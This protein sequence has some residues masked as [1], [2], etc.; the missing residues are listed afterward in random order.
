MSHHEIVLTL[1]DP[2]RR[3]SRSL[4]ASTRS[5]GL[6][7]YGKGRRPRQVAVRVARGYVTDFDEVR[8]AEV[9]RVTRTLVHGVIN[10]EDGQ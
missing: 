4:Q 3:A 8:E 9:F 2:N 1:R 5:R 6:S 10:G 7:F